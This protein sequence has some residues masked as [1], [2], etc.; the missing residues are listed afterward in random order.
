MNAWGPDGMWAD[1]LYGIM[2][3]MYVSGVIPSIFA[4]PFILIGQVCIGVW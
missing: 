1:I 2:G 3:G 4:Y